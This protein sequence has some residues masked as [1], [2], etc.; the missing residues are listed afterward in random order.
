MNILETTNPTWGFYGA[1]SHH[2][3]PDSSVAW[4]LASEAIAKGTGC[5]AEDVR[6]FLD[7]TKGRFFAEGSD[8]GA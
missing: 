1:F 8:R 5:T 6:T 3:T 7:S 2:D 4:P